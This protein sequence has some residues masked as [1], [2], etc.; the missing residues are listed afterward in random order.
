[1]MKYEKIVIMYTA[2]LCKRVDDLFCVQKWIENGYVVEYWNLSEITFK[3]HLT[4]INIPGLTVKH[5]R[6]Y[7]ELKS[8]LST[9]K[10]D[11]TVYM[12][13]FLYSTKAWKVFLYLS[14]F[15]CK[16]AF[17]SNG[18]IPMP[19]TTITNRFQRIISHLYFKKIK[20]F[21]KRRLIDVICKSSYIK[22]ADYYFTPFYP[23]KYKYKVG[24]DTIF[25]YCNSGDYNRTKMIKIKSTNEYILFID[26]YLPYHNDFF[27]AG[28]KSVPPEIYYPSLNRYFNI[29]EEKYGKPVLIAAHPAA[30]KYKENNP[31]EGREVIF[32][33]TPE[34]VSSCF[35]VLT[36]N[37]TAISY[38]IAYMKPI[39]LLTTNEVRKM[40]DFESYTIL[41]SEIL[42][43]PYIN[44]DVS[45][46][47]EFLPID[48]GKY[49]SYKYRYLTNPDAEN[50]DNYEIILKA[51]NI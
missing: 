51:F 22:P 28:E 50:F 9:Q 7:K 36:H 46:N 20:T 1:M 15:N 17:F 6:S 25:V 26:E 18:D 24:P 3:E 30:L 49:T 4:P 41:F 33:R 5:F 19:P 38:A 32:D 31:F 48:E 27:I 2:N 42:N 23:Q 45:D 47:C 8:T 11:K 44:I 43:L 40:K 10:N 21:C 35:G 39:I 34:L 16:I 14:R 37:S 13:W 12:M 29:I